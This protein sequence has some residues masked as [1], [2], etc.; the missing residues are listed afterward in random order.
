MAEDKLSKQLESLGQAIA[1]KEADT[2]YQFPLWGDWQRGIPND[3]ARSA[4]FAAT[5]GTEGK[6]IRDEKIFS[7]D[8]IEIFYRGGRLTQ[9][10]LD[11][12]EAIMHLARSQQEGEEI[13]TTKNGLLRL[14]ERDI[15]GKDQKRL[16]TM[17]TELTATSVQIK[18]EGA[19]LVFWGSLLPEGFH[20]EKTGLLRLKVSRTLIKFFN[21][22]F[23]VIEIKQ[24]KLLARSPLA[25]HLQGWISS[26]ERPY[27]VSVEYLYKL[28]GSETKDLKDF[29]KK[30]KVAL[31][32][33]VS[34]EFLQS[35]EIDE[36]DLVTMVKK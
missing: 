3:F 8:G 34:V 7:Q 1:K 22:G 35:W 24:R 26:H 6:M 18:R 2:V 27:K 21:Q 17:L 16:L 11:V 19:G 12:Y 30:L 13:T 23:T 33:L 36:N 29:R 9:D 14:L 25:R 5:K 28:S 20:D 15:G 31:E 32:K 10:H 4:L